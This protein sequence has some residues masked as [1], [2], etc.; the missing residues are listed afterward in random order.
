MKKRLINISDIENEIIV[1]LNRSKKNGL[2]LTCNNLTL[3]LF[4]RG[5]MRSFRLRIL[6]HSKMNYINRGIYNKERNCYYPKASSDYKSIAERNKLEKLFKKW[7][8][9]SL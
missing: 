6:E 3:I 1:E 4:T 5:K 7:G 9:R 8:F 2:Q